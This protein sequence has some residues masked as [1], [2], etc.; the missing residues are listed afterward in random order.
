MQDQFSSNDDNN[1]NTQLVE[2]TQQQQQQQQPLHLIF[3]VTAGRSGTTLSTRFMEL[4]PGIVV[5]AMLR[6][7]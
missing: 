3:I 1:N 2:L 5:V 4:I 7:N 6:I